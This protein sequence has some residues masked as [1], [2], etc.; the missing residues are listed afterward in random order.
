MQYLLKEIVASSVRERTVPKL[1]F[2]ESERRAL[3]LKDWSR[4][5]QVIIFY[6]ISIT[7]TLDGKFQFWPLLDF[8]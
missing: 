4:Y 2:E 5:K 6:L 7:D 3:L 1:S 8:I